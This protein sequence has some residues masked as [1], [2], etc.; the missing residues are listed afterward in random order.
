MKENK[1]MNMF[2]FALKCKNILHIQSTGTI[3]ETHKINEKKN[4]AND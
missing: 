4:N 3:T 1:Y 2:L